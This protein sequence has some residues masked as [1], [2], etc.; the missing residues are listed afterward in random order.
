MASELVNMA[1]A[2][3]GVVV[4]VGGVFGTMFLTDSPGDDGSTTSG[5]TAIAVSLF[6]IALVAS[7]TL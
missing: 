7:V 5:V 4:A 6:V 2:W 1:Y 3:A